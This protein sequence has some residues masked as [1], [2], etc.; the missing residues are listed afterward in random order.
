[1]TTVLRPSVGKMLPVGEANTSSPREAFYVAGL[2]FD[3]NP[4]SVTD[5]YMEGF[6]VNGN[7]FHCNK[8]HWQFIPDVRKAVVLEEESSVPEYTGGSTNYYKLKIVKPTTESLP[9]YQAECNDIIEALG[10][11]YAEGNI[12]KAVWRRAAARKGV[13]KKGY[14]DGLYDAEKIVFFGQRLLEQEKGEASE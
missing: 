11:N 12:F 14:T 8:S 7:E 1:M 4:L 9:P 3:S 10:M 13:A 5:G 6:E 2:Y